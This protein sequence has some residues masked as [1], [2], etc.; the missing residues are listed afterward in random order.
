[1]TKTFLTQRAA[2]PAT[3]HAN[4]ITAHL[5]RCRGSAIAFAVLVAVSVVTLVT[6]GLMGIQGMTD[7]TATQ[8]QLTLAQTVMDS[9]INTIIYDLDQTLRISEDITPD[10]ITAH[11]QPRGLI[12]NNAY[13]LNVTNDVVLTNLNLNYLQ[14]AASPLE[15][16]KDKVWGGMAAHATNLLVY[17]TAHPYDT[18][19][20]T[21]YARY[22]LRLRGI[23]ITQCA[24][25]SQA[26]IT[27]IQTVS[28][29]EANR[30]NVV[31]FAPYSSANNLIAGNLPLKLLMTDN[32]VG[33]NNR[34]LRINSKLE[35]PQTELR[36]TLNLGGTDLNTRNINKNNTTSILA[37]K[38]TFETYN[39]GMAIPPASS[40]DTAN[41]NRPESYKNI[42]PFRYENKYTYFGPDRTNVI[43]IDL[44][45]LVQGQ[46]T[47]LI[48][49]QP[50]TDSIYLVTNACDIGTTN[51]VNLVFPNDADT[52][53]YGSFNTQRA[54]ARVEGTIGVIS[55]D[56]P[57]MD[58]YVSVTP[59][60]RKLM[61][62][63]N[64]VTNYY[65]T[66]NLEATRSQ[67]HYDPEKQ[68]MVVSEDL[69]ARLRAWA[70]TV[71]SQILANNTA[72]FYIPDATQYRLLLYPHPI[73]NT[74]TATTTLTEDHSFNLTST[75]ITNGFISYNF[76]GWFA[77]RM[78]DK[79]S[80][81]TAM[82]HNQETID[83]LPKNGTLF[84]LGDN[85]FNH[86]TRTLGFTHSSQEYSVPIIT[87]LAAAILTH[88]PTLLTT[89]YSTY[90]Q[91]SKQI[92][93]PL[94]S[95]YLPQAQ[96][97]NTLDDLAKYEYFAETWI[98]IETDPNENLY[99]QY[100]EWRT[101]R[102]E[103]PLTL[104]LS[105]NATYDN[106]EDSLQTTV[107]RA[108]V[109]YLQTQIQ[110]GESL[111]TV[112]I[113]DAFI[114]RSQSTNGLGG[115]KR[116]FES[117]AQMTYHSQVTL[118]T[119]DDL[120]ASH[121]LSANFKTRHIRF[122]YRTLGWTIDN[123]QD[124]S[125]D[126]KP[127]TTFVG[128]LVVNQQINRIAMEFPRNFMIEGQLTIKKRSTTPSL[129]RISKYEVKRN[130]A[131]IPNDPDVLYDI[132]MGGYR[133]RK[134]MPTE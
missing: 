5:H 49:P 127:I 47:N 71:Q 134:E 72:P 89:N 125:N 101:N 84:T 113:P 26:P 32:A 60:P 87:R 79:S 123:L 56:V 95:N 11:L 61:I 44:A 10:D 46:S 54:K 43:V 73:T 57:L 130:P 120:P 1:M 16:T 103:T 78:C 110:Q 76:V 7:R 22:K 105:H 74:V 124:E 75:W 18:T 108:W 133:L 121:P 83:D 116:T 69:V 30:T 102:V 90:A 117:L 88:N 53:I 86:F 96:L 14:L 3:P 85:D 15:P 24:I 122:H 38:Q 48:F 33:E 27:S 111:N 12:T 31:V 112:L 41:T 6:L 118:L 70:D 35:N 94:N 34:Y 45:S 59:Q 4:R 28:D 36:R 29:L 92:L 42:M 115:W 80:L 62:A 129:Y 132:R 66:L 55:A 23:P 81:N 128:R 51:T 50:P 65:T 52:Y 64:Q 114:Q 99:D 119:Q 63:N 131:V 58:P 100:N 2:P 21:Y 82:L 67:V 98:S 104:F 126:N 40:F 17:L 19:E 25:F 91:L 77:N 13:Y 39:S 109:D 37:N 93:T 106:I 20:P 97:T 68:Q 9:T 8:T 107:Y